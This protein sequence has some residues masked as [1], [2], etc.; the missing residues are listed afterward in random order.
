[1]KRV[2]ET[3]GFAKRERGG[4]GLFSRILSGEKLLDRYFLMNRENSVS[5]DV[6][7]EEEE[8]SSFGNI[9]ENLS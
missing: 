7:Y 9:D 8:Y 4:G 5:H 3:R 6:L 1:M 2:D